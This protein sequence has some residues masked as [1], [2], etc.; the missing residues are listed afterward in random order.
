LK[1]ILKYSF[2]ALC[3]MVVFSYDAHAQFVISGKVTDAVSDEP[4]PFA[5][6][7]MKELRSGGTT[8]MEGNYKITSSYISDSICVSYI[9]Y[10]P[11]CKKL[12]AQKEQTIHFS[13]QRSDIS[14][15]EIVILPGENPAHIILRKVIEHKEANH[16]NAL[17]NY[18]YEA[19]SKV[20][21]VLNFLFQPCSIFNI[22]DADNGQVRNEDRGFFDKFSDAS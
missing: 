16:K 22:I 5:N 8:D 7:Y 13:L 10:A 15:Q 3:G 1:H 17:R 12:S 4:I 19:Y 14:L 18:Q 2:L 20:E 21:L 11:L 6:V 9:G